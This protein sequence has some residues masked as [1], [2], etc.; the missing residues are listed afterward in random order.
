MIIK[1]NCYKSITFLKI[2]QFVNDLY[3][4]ELTGEVKIE[5]NEDKEEITTI[6][7]DEDQVSV[8]EKTEEKMEDVYKPLVSYEISDNEEIETIVV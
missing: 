5:E 1:F 8:D 7:I 4:Y 2:T 3:D 6:V